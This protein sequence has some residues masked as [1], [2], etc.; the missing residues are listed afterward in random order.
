MVVAG[1]AS[2]D[3]HAAALVESLRL[4]AQDSP[5]EVRFE[6][7]GA[8][9]ERLRAAGVEEVLRADDLSIVGLLEVGRAVPLFWRALQTLKRAARERRPDAAILVDFPEF[10]LRLARALRR[11]GVPVIYY[12]SPQLWAWRAYRIRQIRQ[13]VDLLLTILPFEKDWFAARG[14]TKVA[15]VGNPLAGEVRP[16]F[17]R[18]EFCRRH[19]LD[20]TNQ[21]IALLPGSRANEIERILPVMI[22]AAREV[23]KAQP[24]AQ[25]VL[26]LASNFSVSHVDKWLETEQQK[27]FARAEF[28]RVVQHET[29]ETLA[30]ADAAAVASGTATLEAALLNTPLVVVYKTSRLN[31]HTLGRLIS[32][33]HFGLVNL[34]AGERVATE[35]MQND[36]N[37]ARLAREIVELLRPERNEQMRAALRETVARLGTGGASERAAQAVFDF[38]LHK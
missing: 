13:S 35:L 28:F 7:F 17:N 36:L 6:F 31:W 3:Q 29:R 21:I 19:N 18:E 14:F 1:E 30:A 16:R 22:D 10:N 27:S 5:P 38:L 33:E 12:I 4:L 23:R 2:G 32:V 37:A 24:S 26:P 11:E 15:F 9:R 34:I 8:T 25:F 20:M